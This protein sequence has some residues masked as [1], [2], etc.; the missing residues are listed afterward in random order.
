MGFLPN[1]WKVSGP[2]SHNLIS[3]WAGA[4]CPSR[5]LCRGEMQDRWVAAFMHTRLAVSS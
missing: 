4:F 3:S 5:M 2:R 1:Q